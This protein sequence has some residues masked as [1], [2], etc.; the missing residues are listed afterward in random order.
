[1]ASM[2]KMYSLFPNSLR[3]GRRCGGRAAGRHCAGIHVQAIVA[4]GGRAGETVRCEV[5]FHRRSDY[6]RRLKR[7]STTVT[8]QS[9]GDG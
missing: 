1:M 5:A 4:E 6:S 8:V 2:V 7:E 3:F 9:S